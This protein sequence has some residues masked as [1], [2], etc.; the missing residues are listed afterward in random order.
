MEM[1]TILK[2]N[3]IGVG[4]ATKDNGIIEQH[5]ICHVIKVLFSFFDSSKQGVTWARVLFM[6]A[7]NSH[8]FYDGM[9]GIWW[10]GRDKKR[11][12]CHCLEVL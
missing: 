12:L 6:V 5:D 8:I 2:P 3:M 9:N 7:N 11:Q 4:Y 10:N 1:H